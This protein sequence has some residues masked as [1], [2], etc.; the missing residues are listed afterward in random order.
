MIKKDDNKIFVDIKD[1]KTVHNQEEYLVKLNQ[2]WE[3]TKFYPSMLYEA[4]GSGKNDFI[5]SPKEKIYSSLFVYGTARY[6]PSLFRIKTALLVDEKK[7]VKTKNGIMAYGDDDTEE[8]YQNSVNSGLKRMA[9]LKKYGSLYHSIL[10]LLSQ[11]YRDS[12]VFNR[13]KMAKDLCLKL[14]TDLESIAKKIDHGIIVYEGPYKTTKYNKDA[15]KWILLHRSSDNEFEPLIF[16]DDKEH[17]YIFNK[18]SDLI[19]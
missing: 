3:L 16:E 2:L 4:D 12:D 11:K 7:G 13:V 10:K 17:H 5:L 1:G 8:F 19:L 18:D 15:E 14:D 6:D 9:V